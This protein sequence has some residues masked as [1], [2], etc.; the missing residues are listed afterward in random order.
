[1]LTQFARAGGGGGAAPEATDWEAQQRITRAARAVMEYADAHNGR[2]PSA[3]TWTDDVARWCLDPSVLRRP[4][5]DEGACGYALNMYLAGQQ[6]PEWPARSRTVL[7]FEVDDPSMNL[8]GD[9]DEDL[10]EKLENGKVPWVALGD[11]QAITT[12]PDLPLA[13]LAVDWDQDET[14]QQHLALLARGLLGYAR[15]HDGKLPEETSWCD[16]IGPYLPPD[17]GA[18]VFTCPA[19]PDFACAYALNL[20]LAGKDVRTLSNHAEHVLLMHATQGVRNEA[21]DAAAATPVGRHRQRWGGAGEVELCVMLDRN[22]RPVPAG[23]A[24]PAPAA[25]PR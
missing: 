10:A 19:C 3:Q 5:L 9:P 12:T 2:L 11:G 13:Q 24:Y 14:C 1:L 8:V 6:L 22:V 16:D 21:V 25:A 15:D 17:A 20:T 4:S 18:S 7:L 23:S